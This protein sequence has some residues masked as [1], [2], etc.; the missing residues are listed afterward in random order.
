MCDGGIHRMWLRRAV[1]RRTPSTERLE[2]DVREQPAM[3]GDQQLPFAASPTL[4][5]NASHRMAR[6]T[7]RFGSSVRGVAVF[8]H[9]SL[10]LEPAGAQF[11]RCDAV[12]I[13][14]VANDRAS[15]GRVE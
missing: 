11:T 3:C 14:Q 15:D 10:D 1:V 12:G 4:R 7:G 2:V 13:A 9:P 6:T 8:D 5:D